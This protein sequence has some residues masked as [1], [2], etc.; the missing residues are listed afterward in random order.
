MVMDDGPFPFGRKHFWKVGLTHTPDFFCNNKQCATMEAIRLIRK[1]ASSTAAV[2][3]ETWAEFHDGRYHCVKYEKVSNSSQDSSDSK[4]LVESV[5]LP[6]SYT[7]INS[8]RC[9]ATG[10]L[11]A[12]HN[13]FASLAFGFDMYGDIENV[14]WT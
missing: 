12:H 9:T 6:D 13:K 7:D 5:P 14:N 8:L 11:H 3:I 4:P 10:Y 2:F 1:A